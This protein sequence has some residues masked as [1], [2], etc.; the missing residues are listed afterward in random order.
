[1]RRLVCWAVS[2]L[3]LLAGTSRPAGAVDLAEP[4]ACPAVEGLQLSGEEN[5]SWNLC[6]KWAWSCI[7]QGLEVNF[8]TKECVEQR[9]PASKAAR[10]KYKYSAFYMPDR[11]KEAN[12][13]SKRFI[14]TVLTKKD[15]A[16]AIPATG[17]R[18]V[19]A[20]FSETVN[21]ENVTTDKN[22]VFDQSIFKDGL[23]LTNFRSE[24]NISLDGA[25]VRGRIYLLRANIG[26]T[27]FLEEGVFDL[28]DAGDARFGGSII[29]ICGQFNPGSIQPRLCLRP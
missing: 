9:S 29:Q 21:L 20:Y 15:Y 13:L 5:Q 22:L 23:R 25:N 7:A 28:L 3:L 18:I 17:I 16:N 19:G 26:G 1:M 8:F 11:F 12:G 14:Y 6:D 24:R 2:G 27:L 4:K 10:A